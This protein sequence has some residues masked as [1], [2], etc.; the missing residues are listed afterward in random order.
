MILQRFE[1]EKGRFLF[2]THEDW[3]NLTLVDGRELE[4]L[5]R[6]DK[7]LRDLGTHAPDEKSI[8]FKFHANCLNSTMMRKAIEK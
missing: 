7:I 3:H 1:T 4:F 2:H 8:T 5:Q 6:W